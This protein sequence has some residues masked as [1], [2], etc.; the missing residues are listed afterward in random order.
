[1]KIFEL[2]INMIY[3]LWLF[4]IPAG[5]LSAIGFFLYMNNSDN[6]SYSIMLSICGCILGIFLAEKVRTKYGLT[7]FFGRI[8][9]TPDIKDINSIDKE[10]KKE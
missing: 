10:N 6:I 7:S 3:W 2:F 8:S 4:I 9:E 1:M 5:I